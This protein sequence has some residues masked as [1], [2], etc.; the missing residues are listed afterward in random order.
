MQEFNKGSEN[1]VEDRQEWQKQYSVNQ[2]MGEFK[3]TTLKSHRIL[4]GD[5]A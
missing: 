1:Y 2:L 5:K 3:Q 4:S